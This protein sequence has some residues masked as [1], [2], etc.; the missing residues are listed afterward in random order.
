[1]MEDGQKEKKRKGYSQGWFG[2]QSKRFMGKDGGSM[3]KW[4]RK[5]AAVMAV[6]CRRSVQ[7]G[8]MH[9]WNE[10][11]Q[12]KAYEELTAFQVVGNVGSRDD[13][14]NNVGEKSVRSGQ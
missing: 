7:R 4:T 6:I 5:A 1:M 13:R 8:V 11:R 14:R 2:C 12:E 3:Q 10:M 9:K